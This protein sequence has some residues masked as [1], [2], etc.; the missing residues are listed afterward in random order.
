MSSHACYINKTEQGGSPATDLSPARNGDGAELK[1]N[2]ES[3]DR[4]PVA[5]DP[6]AA[7]IAV[8]DTLHACRAYA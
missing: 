5:P 4:S 1:A 7:T 8:A 3:C 2:T 6:G